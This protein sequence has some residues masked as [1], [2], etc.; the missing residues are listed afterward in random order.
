M[1]IAVPANVDKIAF[2]DKQFDVTD[3]QVIGEVPHGIIDVPDK[4]G[5][6]LMFRG[7]KNA[8]PAPADKKPAKAA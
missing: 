3:Q 7:Y 6:E 1:R 2:A 8:G 5:A 4:I